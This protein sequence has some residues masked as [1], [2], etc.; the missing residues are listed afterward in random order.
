MGS[1][2]HSVYDAVDAA[3]H[4]LSGELGSL[5]DPVAESH[6]DAGHSATTSSDVT[7][8]VSAD[9][10]PEGNP[11]SSGVTLALGRE[12]VVDRC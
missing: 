10:G 9:G 1:L 7:G 3:E 5:S 8:G 4:V 11:S 12:L 6:C 2:G